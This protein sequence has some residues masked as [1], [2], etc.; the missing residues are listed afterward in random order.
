M[1]VSTLSYLNTIVRSGKELSKRQRV[2]DH[3]D[4]QL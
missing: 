2:Y 3:R 4:R 1:H